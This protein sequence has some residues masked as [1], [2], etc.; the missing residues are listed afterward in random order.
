MV[1]TSRCADS[2]PADSWPPKLFLLLANVKGC[3]LGF[4]LMFVGFIVDDSLTSIRHVTFG[5]AHLIP[6]LFTYFTDEIEGNQCNDGVL[7]GIKLQG[8]M[9]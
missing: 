1:T 8:N 9:F 6:S 3:Q 5:C 2:W 4:P 7:Q